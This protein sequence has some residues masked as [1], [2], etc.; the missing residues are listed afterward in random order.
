MIK[1]TLATV[2]SVMLITNAMKLSDRKSP[3]IIAGIPDFLII[4]KVFFLYVKYKNTN[5]AIKKKKDLKKRI[6]HTLATSND[7]IIKPPQLR[8]KP[9]KSRSVYPGSL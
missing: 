3:P 2:V 6:C 8:Q 1:T 4:L 9:P 5:K 7:L